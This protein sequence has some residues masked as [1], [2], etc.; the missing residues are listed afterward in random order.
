MYEILLSIDS[1]YKAYSYRVIYITL[2]ELTEYILYNKYIKVNIYALIK[3]VYLNE[4]L[5]V[6]FFLIIV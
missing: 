6:K 2:N 5:K 4:K 3:F 1:L